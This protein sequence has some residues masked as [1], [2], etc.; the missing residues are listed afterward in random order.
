[1]STTKKNVK[2]IENLIFY[3]KHTTNSKLSFV[4]IMD[5]ITSN[6]KDFNKIICK[7]GEKIVGSVEL[8]NPLIKDT[9]VIQV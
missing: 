1:M 7:Q 9:L 4:Q 8:D 2:K 3:I 6:N 5:K